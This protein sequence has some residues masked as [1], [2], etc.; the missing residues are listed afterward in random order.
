MDGKSTAMFIKSW[1][2]ICRL[3]FL[4]PELMPNHE[5]R[6]ILMDD[7]LKLSP[8]F[9]DHWM[10]LK[11]K[12]IDGN[13]TTQVR[14]LLPMDKKPAPGLFKRT[15][16]LT[17]EQVRQIKGKLIKSPVSSFT[18]VCSYIWTCLVKAEKGDITKENVYL[19]INVDCRGRWEPP[20][21]EN[22][23][24]NCVTYRFAKA[25]VESLEA[26]DGV[27]VAAAAISEAI[28]S[29]GNGG[30]MKGAEKWLSE[31]SWTFRNE[32]VY[33]IG[34]STWFDLYGADFG[35]GRPRKVEMVSID[36]NSS[37]SLC[38]ARDGDGVIEIGIVLTKVKMEAFA[39]IFAQLSN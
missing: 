18:A 36:R 33:G 11:L 29:L 16:R 15:F 20:V 7:P 31:V 3:G 19:N 10:K 25:K 17:P 2:T 26:G 24:G 23:F 27:A 28:G 6:S 22:Y 39:S 30:V 12:T 32:K 9:I 4:T 5:T 37:L 8:I 14:S 1:A 34:G 21:P 13:D 35:W 38:D